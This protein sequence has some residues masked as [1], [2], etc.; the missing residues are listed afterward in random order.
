M[1][2]LDAGVWHHPA[3]A[4]IS[5][6]EDA[7]IRKGIPRAVNAGRWHRLL[8]RAII[9]FDLTRFYLLLRR[10]IYF[11]VV[12]NIPARRLY[13][14]GWWSRTVLFCFDCWEPKWDQFERL[15]KR[16]AVEVAFFT[17]RQS[18]QEM[19]AR[20]PGKPIIWM[21]EAIDPTPFQPEQVLVERA[22]DVLEYGRPWPSLHPRIARH[23][24]LRGY[25]HLHR[26]GE[27]LLFPTQEDLY[28]GLGNAKLVVCAPQ[29]VTHP[30]LVGKVETMTLRYLESIASGALIFGR[31]PDEM[32]DL[33][34]YDPVIEVDED[35]VELQLDSILR[36]VERYE[37]LRQ[38]NLTRLQEIGTWDVRAEQIVRV[39][40]DVGILETS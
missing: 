12:V 15:L 7:L 28:A 39:L 26:V 32:K 2:V 21:P 34:G 5:G 38:K 6:V 9:R 22:I 20:V 13:P 11:V 35:R 17:A 3:Y 29:S 14:Q 16:N 24:R 18:A 19:A 8:S 10:L 23:C 33:F 36:D 37:D 4:A 1:A 30:H 40:M 25:S 27:P 31:C